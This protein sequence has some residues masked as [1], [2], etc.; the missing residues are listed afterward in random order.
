MGGASPGLD[1]GQVPDRALS[2]V[3]LLTPEAQPSTYMVSH[4]SKLLGA[5][6]DSLR[7][8]SLFPISVK[9]FPYKSACLRTRLS[10]LILH[11]PRD[12][13]APGLT[14]WHPA[15]PHHGTVP[16]NGSVERFGGTA[17]GTAHGTVRCCR[18]AV[19]ECVAGRPVLTWELGGLPGRGVT[20]PFVHVSIR[21][22]NTESV[23]G[24]NRKLV[25]QTSRQGL[26]QGARSHAL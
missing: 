5:K 3:R 22:T 18:V 25:W 23:F 21:L 26:K 6:G 10:P 15:W 9:A 13:P 14:P 2:T 1:Q 12:T 19:C 16:W 7:A 8:L 17:H 4:E 24:D 11:S 20:L